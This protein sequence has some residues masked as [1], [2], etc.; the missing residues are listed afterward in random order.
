MATETIRVDGKVEKELAAE[1]AARVGGGPIVE[2]RAFRFDAGLAGELEAVATD[3]GKFYGRTR[4]RGD[5]AKA[6]A[7]D[8]LRERFAEVR[9]A[10]SYAAT[11][12]R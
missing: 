9:A 12:G 5:A 10:E 6:K 1:F 3:A 2:G 8:R 4:N 11:F 7:A